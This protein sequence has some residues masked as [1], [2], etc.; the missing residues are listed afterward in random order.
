MCGVF[1]IIGHP[2]ASN[3]AYLGLHALQ[4]RGQESAGIVSADSGRLHVHREM[5]LEADIFTAQGLSGLPGPSASARVPC[6][7]AGGSCLKNAQ[8]LMV[9]SAGGQLAVAHNGNLPNA[10]A[11]RD[12]LEQ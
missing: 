12:E 11:L 3:L 4:H 2:E 6:A 1:G 9:A 8:P 10:Q 7:T 5:G